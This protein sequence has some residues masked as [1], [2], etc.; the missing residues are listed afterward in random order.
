MF[1]CL[2]F[3]GFIHKSLESEKSDLK[4]ELFKLAS[5]SKKFLS[6]IGIYI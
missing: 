6:N 5:Y 3:R 4:G 1:R 2:L